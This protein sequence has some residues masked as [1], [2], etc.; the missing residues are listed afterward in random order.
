MLCYNQREVLKMDFR[1]LN[2]FAT[3]YNEKFK[4]SSRELIA[5][6]FLIFE[7]DIYETTS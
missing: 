1:L 6:L 7:K 3:S 5:I 2:P 4:I